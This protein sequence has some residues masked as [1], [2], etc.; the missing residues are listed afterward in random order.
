MTHSRR[1]PRALLVAD[2]FLF[3][4]ALELVLTAAFALV[5]AAA[6]VDMTRLGE[7]LGPVWGSALS[8]GLSFFLL[9]GG[10]FA[11]WSLHRRPLDLV[12]VACIVFG[13]L[14]GLAVSMS[15]LVS[16]ARVFRMLPLGRRQGPPWAGIVFLALLV[17]AV[18]ALSL[19]DAVR[20]L[21][22]RRR[23]HVVL[24]V[25][26]LVALVTLVTLA[27]VVLPWLGAVQGSEMG[28]AGVFMVPF[29]AAAAIG[30]AFAD[31]VQVRRAPVSMEISV[32]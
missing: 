29:A 30:V 11:A 5:A 14:G 27:V 24:D 25:L 23:R 17:L 19:V 2:A 12:A 22:V 20:D 28:E 32:D 7:T 9:L 10:A 8:L 26:R 3:G 13:S 6:R 4:G 1:S 21:S 18:L 31:F 16:G 15:L